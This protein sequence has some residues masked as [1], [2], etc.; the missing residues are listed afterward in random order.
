M[1]FKYCKG[2]FGLAMKNLKKGYVFII[3]EHAQKTECEM[4]M[5]MAFSYL[6]LIL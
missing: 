5:E 6:L 3:L 2:N 1:C 4:G